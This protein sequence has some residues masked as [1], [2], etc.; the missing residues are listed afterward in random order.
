M[1]VGG[2][3]SHVIQASPAMFVKHKMRTIV[4]ALMKPPNHRKGKKQTDNMFT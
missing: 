4:A 2:H 1:K 3:V